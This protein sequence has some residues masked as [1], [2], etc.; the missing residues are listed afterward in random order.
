MVPKNWRLPHK[1]GKRALFFLHHSFCKLELL[2][3]IKELPSKKEFPSSRRR[4][5]W[6]TSFHRFWHT[7][8]YLLQFHP[9]LRPAKPRLME[10][11]RNKEKKK[12]L[13]ISAMQLGM[14]IV[15]SDLLCRNPSSF[16]TEE[17]SDQP[18]QT[19]LQISLAFT[20]QVFA[21]TDASQLSP[22]SLPLLPYLYQSPRNCT[23]SQPRSL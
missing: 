1:K 7:T 2:S 21:F 17:T 3:I 11:V 5:V 4:R 23:R 10:M 22:S 6:V 13:P 20:T 9:I 18:P 12:G 14:T 16:A 19:P 15:L 8:H